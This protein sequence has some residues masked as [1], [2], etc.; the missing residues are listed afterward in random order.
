MPEPQNKRN[1]RKHPRETKESW[2][3]QEDRESVNRG[4]RTEDPLTLQQYYSPANHPKDAA[5]NNICGA[6]VKEK[7]Q[8]CQRPAGQLT[9]HEGWGKCSFH[10]G[11]TPTLRS[12]AAKWVGGEVIHRMTKAY[13]YGGPMD[14]TPTDA[15]LGEVRRAA[16]HV[17]W[18][19]EQLEM[20]QLFLAPPDE[21]AEDQ[22]PTI[23]TLTD[24]QRELIDLYHK[25]RTMLVKSAKTALD[26]GVNE[27]KVRLA[28]MQGAM[29]VN[30]INSILDA[31]GLTVEQRRKVPSVVAQALRG[32]ADPQP[33]QPKMIEAEFHLRGD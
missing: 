17:A 16:G 12:S 6:W 1:R 7:K 11:N 4:P 22:E 10:G 2:Q 33:A 27:R 21:H 25:E 5:G 28:E 9:D 8:K 18:L 20:F 3:H 13:G 29:M 23:T 15:L 30:A 26:A 32:I 31:L 19:G 24:A 14:M